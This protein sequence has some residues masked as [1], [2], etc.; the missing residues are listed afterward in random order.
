MNPYPVAPPGRSAHELGL[1]VDLWAGNDG[2]QNL[3]A[4]L[5][6]QVGLRR[7]LGTRDAVHFE[8]A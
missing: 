4:A 6:P 7:P 2:Q 3:L 8:L 1:A 5:A